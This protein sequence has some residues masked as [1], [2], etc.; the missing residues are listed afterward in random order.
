MKFAILTNCMGA[1]C[2]PVY[3]SFLFFFFVLLFIYC[4][5]NE[6][7]KISSTS[8]G[9]GYRVGFQAGEHISR[10]GCMDEQQALACGQSR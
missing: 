10:P 3:F 4:F 9:G 6:A 2:A 8:I 7:T 5:Y 1:H